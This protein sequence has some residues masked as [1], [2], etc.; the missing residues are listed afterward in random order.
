MK[1]VFLAYQDEQQLE[2]MPPAARHLFEEACRAGEQELI[3]SG[4]LFAREDLQKDSPAI[5]VRV[6]N[7]RL[8]F[9]DSPFVPAKG[10]SVRLFL[11]R[12]RDLNAAI[13]IAARMPQARQGLIEV[14]PIVEF[15]PDNGSP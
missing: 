4:H 5:V 3:Q 8:I 7:G 2:A 9:T 1:Y 12:T 10:L 15:E 6:R 11:V 14:R 13:Q